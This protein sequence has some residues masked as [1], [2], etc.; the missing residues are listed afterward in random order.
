MSNPISM[1]EHSYIVWN[2]ELTRLAKFLYCVEWPPEKNPVSKKP[3]NA[4]NRNL[5]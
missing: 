4:K 1:R 3:Q 2:K 5:A